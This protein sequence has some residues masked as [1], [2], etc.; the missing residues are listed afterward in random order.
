MSSKHIKRISI[1]VFIILT[2]AILPFTI[3]R[4]DRNNKLDNNDLLIAYESL[5][6]I[7]KEVSEING[8]YY[9]DYFYGKDVGR[10]ILTYHDENLTRVTIRDEKN[11]YISEYIGNVLYNQYDFKRSELSAEI[12]SYISPKFWLTGY[13]EVK[14][15][16]DPVQ[17]RTEEECDII[18][19][20]LEQGEL[21]SIE[22]NRNNKVIQATSGTYF[23]N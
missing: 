16:Y 15:I 3:Y 2:V 11:G 8:V 22:K 17:I 6:P 9:E 7:N 1:F 20:L 5:I 12:K 21:D 4:L 23:V 19:K 14:E 13:Q 18:N 10:V